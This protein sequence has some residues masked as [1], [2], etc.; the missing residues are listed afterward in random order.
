MSELSITGH[1]LFSA[2]PVSSHSPPI[3][4]LHS[5]VLTAAPHHRSTQCIDPSRTDA[6]CQIVLCHSCK[7]LQHLWPCLPLTDPSHLS[8]RSVPSFFETSRCVLWSPLC[9][10]CYCMCARRV[11]IH[12]LAHRLPSLIQY[13]VSPGPLETLWR[14]FSV[15]LIVLPCSCWVFSLNIITNFSWCAAVGSW[16]SP[17]Q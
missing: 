15:L 2:W 12:L 5:P 3:S 7:N 14:D 11:N 17:F 10:I 13:A 9:H 8:Q 1:L 4:L 16:H 6:L